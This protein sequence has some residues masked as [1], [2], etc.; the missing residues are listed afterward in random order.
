MAER[1]E[2]TTQK[3]Q[4][5]GQKVRKKFLKIN[6]QI[7]GCSDIFWDCFSANGTRRLWGVKGIMKK[8]RP[9]C[10]NSKREL[11]RSVEALDMG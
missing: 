2:R 1:S 4:R 10:K 5:W 8:H 11:E 3:L 9:I 7:G 6:S